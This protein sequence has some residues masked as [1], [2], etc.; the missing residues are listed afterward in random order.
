MIFKV[1]KKVTVNLI[2]F[3]VKIS[4]KNEGNQRTFSDKSRENLSPEDP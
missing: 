1:M 3:P 2:Y 4:F